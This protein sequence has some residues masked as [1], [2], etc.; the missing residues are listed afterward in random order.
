MI[1]NK[2][3]KD[4]T[5]FKKNIMKHILI[6]LSTLLILL[7]PSNKSYAWGKKGHSLVAEIAFH[8]LDNNTQKN[9]LNYLNGMSIEDAAN[10]MDSMRDDHSYDY[11]KPF[12]YVN[13]EKGAMVN[14]PSGDNIIRVLNSTL[15]DL[16]N[17]NSLSKDE[18]RTRLFY[19]FHLVGDLHQ[20]LHVGYGVDKG[21]NKTQA[22]FFGK[23]SNLHAIWDTD[24]IEYKNISLEDCLNMNKYSN[25]E[26]TEIQ[27]IDVISW[28][29]D[30]RSFL[31]NIYSL[32]NNKIDEVYIDKS[33]PIVKIQL[34]K[35]GLRLASLLENYFK[36]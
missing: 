27:K 36:I 33:Y 10:W 23:G 5:N 2:S 17:I 6:T 21:G 13:F 25:R 32:E 30:S 29:R 14:E 16:D 1:F 8:Y 22:S 9:V 28:A 20:P 31:D 26:L 4:K 34:M 15:R 24:I 19:L 35:A 11:M 3:N 18:I 12:H 7:I